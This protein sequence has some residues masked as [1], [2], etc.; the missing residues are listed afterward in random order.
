MDLP[1]SCVR[2]GLTGNRVLGC[3]VTVGTPDEVQLLREQPGVWSELSQLPCQ[4]VH[5]R[6]P[7]L[8]SWKLPRLESQS[9]QLLAADSTSGNFTF[10]ATVAFSVEHRRL[11]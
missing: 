10:W 11:L 1:E 3:L 6:G 5:S 4:P 8:P 9:C 2:A 7:L